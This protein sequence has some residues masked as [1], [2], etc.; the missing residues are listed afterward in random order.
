MAGGAKFVAGELANFGHT[1]AQK[2]TN[3]KIVYR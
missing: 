1:P 2:K 3:R